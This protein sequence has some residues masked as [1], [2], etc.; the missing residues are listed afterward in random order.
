M[1]EPRS[2]EN[3]VPAPPWERSRRRAAPVRVPL[4]LGRIVDAAFTVLDREGYDGLSMRQVAAELGVA[5]S[6]LYAHVA[7]KDELLERMYA[8]LFE[9]QELPE[10][11]PAR[12]REQV[13]DYAVQGRARLL[14]HRDMARISMAHVPFSPEL[15]PH[16]ERMLAIFRAAGLPDRVAATAGD[17]ISTF[18]EGFTYEQSMWQERQRNTDARTWEEMRAT[19]KAYFD[20]LPPDRFPNLLAMADM[21][22]GGTYDARFELGLEIIIRGLASYIEPGSPAGQNGDTGAPVEGGGSGAPRDGG[23]SGASGDSGGSGAAG[24]GGGSGAAGDSGG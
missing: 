16:V 18:L 22:F 12:W 2:E 24:E 20:T 19:I 17:M 15:L 23:G 3:E 10:P 4:T 6:A 14:S 1:S 9:G 11:D 21:M 5:V 13:R 8:R 7:S